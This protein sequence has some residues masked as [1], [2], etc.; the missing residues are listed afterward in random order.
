MSCASK[1]EAP[2]LEVNIAQPVVLS[3]IKPVNNLYRL[4]NILKQY[5]EYKDRMHG[6]R[7]L[8]QAINYEERKQKGR[9]SQEYLYAIEIEDGWV[10]SYILD[11]WIELHESLLGKDIDSETISGL[12]L[13]ETNGGSSSPYLRSRNLLTMAALTK[14]VKKVLNRKDLAKVSRPIHGVPTD[15]RFLKKTA[16]I[17]VEADEEE[18][19]SHKEWEDGLPKGVFLYWKGL[20]ADQEGKPRKAIDLYLKS[21]ELVRKDPEISYLSFQIAKRLVRLYKSQGDRIKASWAYDNWVECWLIK[22]V[23]AK[24]VEMDSIEF[25]LQKINIVLWSARY[26]ALLGKYQKAEARGRRALNQLESLRISSG[27][28]ISSKALAMYE[29]EAYHVLAFRVA[30]EKGSYDE[31][32]SWSQLGLKIKSLSREWR[33]RF[34]WHSGLYYFL[35]GQWNK[36]ANT[37]ETLLQKDLVKLSR[38][39][40]LFWL[41]RALSNDQQEDKAYEVFNDLVNEFPNSYYSVVAPTQLDIDFDQSWKKKLDIEIHTDVFSDIE[42]WDLSSLV[43]SKVLGP[44]LSRAE[45]LVAAKIDHL[46][47][48]MVREL[49]WNAR[50]KLTYKSNLD[51]W[52]YLSRLS[53][54]A[55]QYIEAMG[56]TAQLDRQ[57]DNFWDEYPEQI[58]VIYPMPYFQ[59]YTKYAKEEGLDPL[60][61]LSI[62]R[63]E[64]GFKSVARSG[65]DAL[66]LMQIIEVT[67]RK[68]ADKKGL[69]ID[70]FDIDLV[71]PEKNIRL[72]NAYLKELNILYGGSLPAMFGA[73]NAGEFAMSIWRSRRWHKDTLL[74][75]E[76][77]PFGETREYI[78]KVWRNYTVYLNLQEALS[79][80]LSDKGNRVLNTN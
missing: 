11:R 71:N 45:L 7:H 78:K 48:V 55:G 12:I 80:G 1:R 14:R 40:V 34:I 9:A 72:G 70:D 77:I 25:Q 52:L 68:L 13:T 41:G 60:V 59:I 22:G 24:T 23:D 73:Y 30:I 62:T 43:N 47:G 61:A 16:R 42:G 10:G 56:I 4:D 21:N 79:K 58:W 8:L 51:S 50:K 75:V 74:A 53:F 76:M 3:N 49:L 57:Y 63:Q 20:L 37:W 44:L 69:R 5:P 26:L 29:A 17:F 28:R 6:V 66:G 15:D 35:S 31:A 46:S 2:K 65:A 38:A 67:A 27:G 32:I 36:A 18:R 39:Q 54:A 19:L 64:S 33:E